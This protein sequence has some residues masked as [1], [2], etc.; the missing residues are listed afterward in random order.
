MIP[1]RR[2]ADQEVDKT[3]EDQIRAAFRA[4]VT[5]PAGVPEPA[6]ARRQEEPAMPDD[7]ADLENAALSDELK[8]GALGIDR[9]RSAADR[10]RPVSAVD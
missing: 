8:T 2:H 7:R 10:L 5:R 1:H 9:A 3:A 4:A 6:R